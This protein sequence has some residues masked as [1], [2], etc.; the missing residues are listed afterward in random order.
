MDLFY[1]NRGSNYA[2][3]FKKSDRDKKD[4]E[5]QFNSIF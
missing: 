1:M 5:K 2:E 3:T 4:I